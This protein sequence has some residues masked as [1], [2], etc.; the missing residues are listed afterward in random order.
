MADLIKSEIYGTP[1][2]NGTY[3]AEMDQWPL[4]APE[5]NRIHPFYDN[6]RQGRF[7]TTRCKDCGHV[8]FPPGVI[9]HKCWSENLEWIDL[10]KKA[11]IACF[12]ETQAGAPAGFPAPLILAWIVYP[13]GSPI[14]Q[15]I[16]RIINCKE[17]ELKEGDEV[18]IVVYDVP[19]HPM[20]VKK[21]TK[22]CDRV[23]YAFEPVKK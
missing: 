10:P 20:D 14:K 13:Q 19:S 2:L 4:E 11:T 8:S 23:Y 16:T 7:T 17:G 12:T 3:V 9:C 18:Q 21:E 6:L 22:I 5:L 15:Q 1:A